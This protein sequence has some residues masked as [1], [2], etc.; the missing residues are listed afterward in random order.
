VQT[1]DLAHYKRLMAPKL[2]DYVLRALRNAGLHASLGVQPHCSLDAWSGLRMTGGKLFGTCD[3]V[4][5]LLFKIADR[6]A[7]SLPPP[8]AGPLRPRGLARVVFG[9][10]VQLKNW[11]A[12]D[13]VLC[14]TQE[15]QPLAL[16]PEA[17][18]FLTVEAARAAQPM[19]ASFDWAALKNV[20]TPDIMAFTA[21][22]RA[23]V[24][25]ALLAELAV[26]S[27]DAGFLPNGMH[28][29]TDGKL[30]ATSS[31]MRRLIETIC[32]CDSLQ[33][34]DRSKDFNAAGFR[35]LLVQPSLQNWLD[36]PELVRIDG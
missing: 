2:R 12:M 10:R 33:L 29:A 22:L 11:L 31:Q 7:I 19:N 3:E 14:I 23:K 5:T 20:R 6:D 4:T 13:D 8:H 24:R 17:V 18:P 9:T 26:P 36:L 34:I 16:R 32:A 28:R 27:D 15:Q 21:T 25:V 1:T 30:V 35:A